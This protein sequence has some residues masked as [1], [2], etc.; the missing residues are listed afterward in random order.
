[1]PVP[2]K[3]RMQRREPRQK[4]VRMQRRESRQRTL[5]ALQSERDIYS[6]MPNNAAFIQQY[7]DWLGGLAEGD[8]MRTNVQMAIDNLQGPASFS[9]PNNNRIARLDERIYNLGGGAPDLESNESLYNPGNY[10][11]TPSYLKQVGSLP[12][13]YPRPRPAPFLDDLGGPYP[14]P[15]P[16]PSLN[17]GPYPRPRPA[18]IRSLAGGGGLNDLLSQ[19]RPR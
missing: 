14:R 15:R 19:S 11:E 18:P 10:G 5:G 2:K 4:K 17:F 3:V 12:G 9:T 8:P 7:Q 16:A 1:M 13:P 6:P